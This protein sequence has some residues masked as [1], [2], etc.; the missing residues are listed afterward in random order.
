M[1][2]GKHTFSK[3]G[4][5]VGDKLTFDPHYV[6]NTVWH[7]GELVEFDPYDP[8]LDLFCE[9][10]EIALKTID[11]D[12]YFGTMTCDYKEHRIIMEIDTHER[13]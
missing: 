7:T 13:D 1:D 2:K 3:K 4:R 9:G 5:K 11:G 8:Q 12:Y 10:A 6:F